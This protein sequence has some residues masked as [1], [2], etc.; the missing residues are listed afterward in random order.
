MAPGNELVSKAV[1]RS[2]PSLIPLVGC[3]AVGCCW[4]IYYL[5]RLAW[6]NPDVRWTDK[7]GELG[8]TRWPINKQHHFRFYD[9]I[10]RK[11]Y[12][13]MKFPEGR[14]DID[15]MWKTYKKTKQPADK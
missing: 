5:K 1:F 15:L 11:E 12:E 13:E 10:T 2:H 6:N 3:V 9:P 7:A 8:N 14:P 4:S